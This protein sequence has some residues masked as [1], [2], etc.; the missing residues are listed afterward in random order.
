MSKNPSEATPPLEG[1]AV[2]TLTVSRRIAETVVLLIILIVGL[3][4]FAGSLN[5]GSRS[6]DV[7]GASTFPKALS[8]LLMFTTAL[9]IIYAL[10][11]PPNVSISLK[12][13]RAVVI[14]IVLLL[15]F[16]PL[17]GMLG[18][19]VLIVPWLVI[20]GWAARVRSPMLIVINLVTVLFV[21][22]VVFQMILRTPMP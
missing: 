18:Y 8:L 11:A 6:G 7:V 12:R 19:Y 1:V 2:K 9:A 10:R 16:P 13:P 22:R 14:A 5:I 17:V 3:F 21:A 4:F 20:F 15:A